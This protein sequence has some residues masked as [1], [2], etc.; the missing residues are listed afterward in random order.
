MIKEKGN[1]ILY[2]C[3][4]NHNWQ[5]IKI[6]EDTQ[7]KYKVQLYCNTCNQFTWIKTTKLKGV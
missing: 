6:V 1:P 7:N 5:A 4:H 3:K 2:E